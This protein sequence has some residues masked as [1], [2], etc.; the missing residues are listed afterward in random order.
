[1][2]Y[3]YSLLPTHS[4]QDGPRQSILTNV[5]LSLIALLSLACFVFVVPHNAEYLLSPSQL[6]SVHASAYPPYP[7][8]HDSPPPEDPRPPLY[9][10]YTAYETAL[11]QHDESSPYPEGSHTK[12]IF[13]ANHGWGAGWGNALQEMIMNAHLAHTSGRAFVF[14]NYTWLREGP[15]YSDFNGKLIPSRIPLPALVAGPLAGYPYSN[16]TTAHTHPRFVSRHYYHQVC[17]DPYVL[18]SNVVR[19]TIPSDASAVQTMDIWLSKLD[20]IDARCIEIKKDTPQLFDIWLI[21]SPRLH[22]I[23]P[24]LVESP[25][26]RD[27]A[28]SPLIQYA[29]QQNQ[30]HFT[31]SFLSHKPLLSI[32]FPHLT[33][34]DSNT[35]HDDSFTPSSNAD[36]DFTHSLAPTPAITQSTPLPL[37]ALHLR[38]GDFIEHCDNLYSWNSLYTGF[39]TLPSLPDR[40]F[41]ENSTLKDEM[42]GEEIRQGYR[43]KCL[44]DANKVRKRV[45]KAVA[46]WREERLKQERARRSWWSC[47]FWRRW[48]EEGR[49]KKMLRKVYIMTNG[50][51]EWLEELKEALYDDG[52]RSVVRH[53]SRNSRSFGKE[54]VGVE[55][56]YDFEFAWSWDEVSTSRDLELGW[57]TKYVAQAL[58]MYVGQRAEVFVGNGFSSL[59]GIVVLLRTAAGVEPWRTRFW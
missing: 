11:P 30:H 10:R 28:W 51:R 3:P 23:L 56:E 4:G 20:S 43:D 50:D 27:F 41:A 14:D 45:I 32:L 49:V 9:Q 12:F 38:R 57:E 34:R 21:G 37:L 46:E 25:V 44:V 52:R 17:P 31:S 58:D 53:G 26:V 36:F 29:F 55:T 22:D 42:S 15:E 8:P 48:G 1:M 5:F 16:S 35:I 24:S 13:F 19:N 47:W 39:N 6:W 33:S 40:F 54:D 18:D 2:P 59:T 7:I